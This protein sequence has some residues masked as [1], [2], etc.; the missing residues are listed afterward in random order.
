M[1]TAK[2]RA[3][4]GRDWIN[5][6]TWRYPLA[7]VVG[8][9]WALAFP[10]PGWAGLAWIVPG[11]L[12]LLS[13]GLPRAAAFRVGYV[14]G[15]VHYLVALRWLLHMP[16][17]AGA[18][19]G[20]AVLSGYC[21]VYAGAWTWFTS[22]IIGSGRAVVD[23]GNQDSW[24]MSCEQLAGQSWLRRA[25]LWAT[26]A[27]VWVAW[28]MVRARMFSGFAWNLLGVSHWR[29][30]PLIQ[31][32]RV[33]G[34]YGVSFLICWVSLALTGAI[35]AL[36]HRPRD[37]WGWTA[38]TRLPLL[39]VL[40]VS[41]LGFW[42]VLGRRRDRE[43]ASQF[44]RLA[45]VQPSVP[46]T[47]QWDPAADT[48]NF[49]KIL[50]LSA[51]ALALKPDVLI[52]PEGSFGLGD[53]TWAQ[54]TNLTT[55]AGVSWIFN[56]TMEN[57]EGRPLNSA[58]WLSPAGRI[59]GQYDKCRL[60]IFGEYVPLERWLPFLR[61]VTPIGSSF[62][63]GTEPVPFSVALSGTN[64]PVEI[65]PIICFEDTFPHGVRRHIRSSTDLL[66]EITNDAWF[67]ESS[68]QWQ[69]AASAAFRAIEN[70]VP[71]VR[72]ANNGLSLWFDESGVPHDLFG[73]KENVYG[74]G[75]QIVR[76]PVGR[77]RRTTFY[78][79]HGDVFGWTC[80]AWTG[81]VLGRAF[82]SNHRAKLELAS[83]GR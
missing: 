15:V 60:V 25:T 82:R 75:F 40:L 73:A 45:L 18:I 69:H 4:I 2:C 41:G 9:I 7:A 59:R 81:W 76:I 23:K 20:W 54:I 44:V 56:T 5:P 33:T 79:K 14:A 67:G 78:G 51:Q 48:A 50:G 10:E 32:A 1:V 27:A 77:A 58:V 3:V 6:E 66:L 8:L 17:S 29:Q 43:S 31:I 61:Y 83:M 21:A 37:R 38:E 62:A 53:E 64:S 68:A 13:M 72:A 11:S 65:S 28:E 26:L 30:V 24:R 47:L 42:T 12:F 63:A 19:A 74:A 52:W 49:A 70:G 35:L 71:V 22:V 36:I 57:T 55:A 80:V 16:H 46:Q 34:V 39:A